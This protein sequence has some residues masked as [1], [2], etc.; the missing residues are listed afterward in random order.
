[1][2]ELLPHIESVLVGKG[3]KVSRPD[4]TEQ[5]QVT[6][7]EDVDDGDEEQEEEVLPGK[8]NFEETSEDEE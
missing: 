4:Y 1:L 7:K 2:V 8:K 6:G 5:T 3:E